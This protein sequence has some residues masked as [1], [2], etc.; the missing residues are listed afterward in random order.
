MMNNFYKFSS[1]TGFKKFDYGFLTLDGRVKALSR[2]TNHGGCLGQGGG[3][4][5]GG[6]GEV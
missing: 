6:G 5:G 2:T 3:G 1:R 4:G